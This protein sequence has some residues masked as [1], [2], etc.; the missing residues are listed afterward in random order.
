[1]DGKTQRTVGGFGMALKALLLALFLGGCVGITKAQTPPRRFVA[2]TF[3]DLPAQRGNLAQMREITAKVIKSV[4]KHKIPA[5]GFVN[6]GKLFTQKGEVDARIALLRQW[7]EAGLELGN[8]TFSHINNQQAPLADYQDDI[9]RGATVTRQ[10]LQEQGLK[11][12]YFRHPF[13][14]TGITNEYKQGIEQFLAARNYAVA[15]V[16]IDNA[17]YIYAYTYGVAQKRGDTETM[18][19]LAAGYVPHM[20]TMCEYFERVSRE[21]LGYEVKQILLVHANEINAEYFDD[22]VAMLKRRG[23]EFITLEETLK[24]PAYRLPDAQMRWG[25]SWLHRWMLAKGQA[26]RKDEPEPPPEIMK[27]YEAAQRQP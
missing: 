16:T 18:K 22:V 10:L 12:R 26:M 14:F 6:E 23:Y 2:V 27:L 13:L 21:S 19:R 11:L 3:D 7:T 15:P 8:H 17:D 1:M 5:V 9:I 25:R 4:V 20:E 24:D